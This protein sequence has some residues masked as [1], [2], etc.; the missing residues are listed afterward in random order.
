M[1]EGVGRG[2]ATR[3]FIQHRSSWR[4]CL[5]TFHQEHLKRDFR[6]LSPGFFSGAKF[7]SEE[8]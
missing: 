6:D 3:P 7:D 5:G 2:C 1:P 8:I 4:A